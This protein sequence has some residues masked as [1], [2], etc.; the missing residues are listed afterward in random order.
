MC[1][2][3]VAM[4]RAYHSPAKTVPAERPQAESQQRTGR[5]LQLG[6]RARGIPSAD[7][8]I[9][10]AWSVTGLMVSGSKSQDVLHPAVAEGGFNG[11]S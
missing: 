11:S 3:S 4:L 10:Y 1:L 2:S 8:A 9:A 7:G 5:F 6:T